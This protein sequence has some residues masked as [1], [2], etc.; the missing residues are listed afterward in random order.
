VILIMVSRVFDAALLRSKQASD[1]IF[2]I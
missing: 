1:L 2:I